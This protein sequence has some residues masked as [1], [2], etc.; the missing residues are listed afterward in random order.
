[1]N[2]Y[3]PRFAEWA[4][5]RAGVP[6][7][8]WQRLVAFRALEHD[9]DGALVW[10]EVLVTVSRQVGKS[11]LLREIILWR[12]EEGP[13]LFGNP[14]EV[15]A[16]T[17]N[18]L[19]TSREI[20]RPALAWAEDQYGW[21]ARR[22]NGETMVEHPN[23]S[24]WIVRALRSVGY[25]FS[26]AMPVVDEAWDVPVEVV[27]DQ[28]APTMVTRLSAQLWLVS[29]AHPEATT[30]FP[31]RRKVALAQLHAPEESLLVEWSADPAL[32][33]DSQEAWRQ[34]S[35]RWDDRR[36]KF[37]ARQWQT[38]EEGSFI[39]QWLSRWPKASRASLVAE[40]DWAG[41]AE[42]GIKP[43]DGVPLVITLDA[44]GGGGFSSVVAWADDAGVVRLVAR[45][46]SHRIPALTYVTTMAQEHP[47]SVLMLGASLEALVDPLTFP[48][49]VSLAGVRETRQATHL[50]QGL[51]QEGKIR[52][53]GSA[54]LA[55]QVGWAVIVR[56]DVGPV[57]SGS[58]SPGPIDLAR[59]AAWAAW[60]AS[61]RDSV[62]PG[63]F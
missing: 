3:G 19:D 63:I 30:L 62:T 2:T 45:Q 61:T 8:W 1:V 10:E 16:Y 52:H 29:S 4:E 60:M 37:I 18:R 36:R 11:H 56:T 46:D 34:G 57:L 5:K 55:A 12:L 24:R 7:Y 51:A 23:G 6:L 50:F 27:D 21:K 9:A 54:V 59:G 26:L 35:P 38:S 48:G 32:P 25:G 20:I 43:P 58:R 41:M 49:E 22:A 28:L 14:E 15:V 40:D 47:G 53:D 13:A 33:S 44:I 42:P 39:A 17:A 31:D